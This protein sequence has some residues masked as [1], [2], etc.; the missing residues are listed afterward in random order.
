ME[1]RTLHPQRDER[2]IMRFAESEL[3]ERK[4]RPA[5]ATLDRA[6]RDEPKSNRQGE[7][8]ARV[9]EAFASGMGLRHIV[10]KLRVEPAKVR[11]LFAEWHLDL[12]AGER[13][14][15]ADVCARASLRE[16]RAHTA[17]L[18]AS[19]SRTSQR[20]NEHSGQTEPDSD[21]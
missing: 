19:R 16:Q 8:A 1:G 21:A 2:G 14:R 13:Q 5:R 4:V 11:Q 3:P 12:I 20:R 7:V 15:R 10:M 9:F 6:T 18:R 17:W